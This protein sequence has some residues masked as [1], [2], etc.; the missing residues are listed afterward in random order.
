MAVQ[1]ARVKI[2]PKPGQPKRRGRPAKGIAGDTRAAL[3][4]ATRSLLGQSDANYVS[5]QRIAQKAGVDPA[6]INY[7]FG[8]RDRSLGGHQ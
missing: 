1:N 7:H 4:Q 3:I 8:G 6:M 5:V 2:R